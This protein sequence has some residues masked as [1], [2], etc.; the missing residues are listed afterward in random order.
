MVELGP[1]VRAWGTYPGGQS[2][3]PASSRYV[4]RIRA[5]SNG[6]LDTLF[7][8]GT[9]AAAQARARSELDLTPAR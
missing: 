9:V 5:W 7:V 3:N 8:P 4:D 1:D 6:E 2:G